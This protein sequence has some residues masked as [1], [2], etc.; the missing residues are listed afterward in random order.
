MIQRADLGRLE[1]ACPDSLSGLDLRLLR[2]RRNS[3]RTNLFEVREKITLCYFPH[4]SEFCVA[5][6]GATDILAGK[7]FQVTR[8][9][10]ES[11]KSR[12]RM[13]QTDVAGSASCS[14]ETA[15][16][17]SRPDRLQIRADS[18]RSYD[19]SELCIWNS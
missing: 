1:I 15:G 7:I 4:D 9:L 10:G 11:N 16:K 5:S 18:R 13:G 8:F 12:C 19:S 6:L 17:Q 3:L 14:K 2:Y